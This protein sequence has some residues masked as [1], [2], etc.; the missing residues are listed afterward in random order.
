MLRNWRVIK[1]NWSLAIVVFVRVKTARNWPRELET[2]AYT[3]KS[4]RLR[5]CG[6]N[7]EFRWLLLCFFISPHK[8]ND[9]NENIF[10]LSGYRKNWVLGKDK[11]HLRT[12]THM[13]GHT[14]TREM[15]ISEWL[16]TALKTN[17]RIWKSSAWIFKQKAVCRLTCHEWDE[18]AWCQS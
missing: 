1:Q 6:F 13:A 18:L 3:T 15:V 7:Q 4:Q 9:K 11:R 12:Y 10:Q 5:V 17:K 2:V 14:K 8:T 16:I